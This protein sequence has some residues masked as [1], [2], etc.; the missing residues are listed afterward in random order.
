MNF[1]RPVCPYLPPF[2]NL[3]SGACTFLAPYTAFSRN[4]VGKSARDN[5]ESYC[6]WFLVH[7]FFK[8]ISSNGKS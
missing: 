1:F 8:E 5:P 6:G 7:C 4:V 3:L 2:A